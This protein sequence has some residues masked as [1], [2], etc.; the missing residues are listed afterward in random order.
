MNWKER[1][2]VYIANCKN[3]VAIMQQAIRV[4]KHSGISEIC[5]TNAVD[6]IT[7]SVANL[8][9]LGLSGEEIGL[10][11]RGKYYWRKTNC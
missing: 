6:T 3:E 1:E 10:V 9:D 2:N 11:M 5:R 4:A 7:E 8:C